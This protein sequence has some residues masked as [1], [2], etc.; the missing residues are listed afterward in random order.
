SGLWTIGTVANGDTA[1]LIITATVNAGTSGD[2]ITNSTT[3][4]TGDQ[5]DPDTTTDDL[6]AEITILTDSDIVLTKIVDNATPNAGDTVTYTV[7]VTNKGAAVVT[8]LV[9]T[10]ALPIGLIVGTGT[11]SK[12]TWSS[13]AWNVGTLASGEEVSIVITAVVGL[14]QDGAVLTNTVT[15]TQDQTDSNVTADDASETITV[16]SSNLV[17]IKT[18]SDDTPNEG[19][20]IVYTITVENKGGTDATGVTLTDLLPIGVTYVSNDQGTAYNK[21]S[22]L[23]TIGSIANGIIAT[24][25][26]TATVDAGTLGDKITNTTSAAVGDQTDPTTVGDDL[27]VDIIVDIP[28]VA[29]DDS[30]SGLVTGTSGVLM[31]ISSDDTLSDG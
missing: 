7:T 22:G 19:D 10:D 17:T 1:T 24:L 21:G 28:P 6:E 20:T 9:V 5:T 26:I 14:D 3:A 23:W 15:N 11:P 25:N 16:S 27:D 8:G 2:T 18:V 4:A 30:I 31:D 13:P 12:G 29:M